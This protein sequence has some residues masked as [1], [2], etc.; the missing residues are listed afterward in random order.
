M[1]FSF[2]VGMFFPI[3]LSTESLHLQLVLFAKLQRMLGNT[4]R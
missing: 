4:G 3:I 2:A 1:H